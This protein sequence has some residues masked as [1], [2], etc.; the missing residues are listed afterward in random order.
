MNLKVK[1]D[2][3]GLASKIVNYCQFTVDNVSG[4]ITPKWAPANTNGLP[5]VSGDY[6]TATVT[7]TN[8]PSLNSQ[9][10]WKTARLLYGDQSVKPEI[11]STQYGVFFTKYAQNHPNCSTCPDCPNW[12][13]YWKNGGVCG[14]PQGSASKYDIDITYG[15]VKL[16]NKTILLG[17]LA[18]EINGAF[19][20]YDSGT[21]TYGSITTG[22]S[23][24]GIQCVA[25]TV[26]HEKEHIKNFDNFWFLWNPITDRD[27]DG[28]PNIEEMVGYGGIISDPDNCDT[29]QI[30]DEDE[31]GNPISLWYGDNEIRCIKAEVI[32]DFDIFPEKDWAN[33]GCQHKDQW[34][35][36]PNTNP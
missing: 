18:A 10:G 23:G 31:N 30:G 29:F 36:R 25:E 6:L 1:I 20:T 21:I 9:F 22:G 32:L 35:P 28:M 15:Q 17:P 26:Q 33:P 11:A 13:Y 2:P 19:G 3:P 24:K 4:S 16:P 34:G 8:L 27:E 14:I 7:F 5:T 12:F